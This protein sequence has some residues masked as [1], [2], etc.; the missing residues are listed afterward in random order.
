MSSSSQWSDSPEVTFKLLKVPWTLAVDELPAVV[1]PHGLSTEWQW[2]ALLTHL[3]NEHIA[4]VVD[5]F[6][7]VYFAM[8]SFATRQNAEFTG[9][10]CLNA[11]FLKTKNM[12]VVPHFERAYL[13]N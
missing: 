5:L 4:H 3:R 11:V 8:T 13:G 1:P 9:S 10:K 7:Y 12:F 6:R 2:Y